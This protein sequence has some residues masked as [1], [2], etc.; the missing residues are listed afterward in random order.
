MFLDWLKCT[1]GRHKQVRIHWNRDYDNAPEAED[2]EFD[3]FVWCKFLPLG[4]RV[5]ENFNDLYSREAKI[6]TTLVEHRLGHGTRSQGRRAQF[7]CLGQ[8]SDLGFANSRKLER[9]VL[10]GSESFYNFSRTEVTTWHPKPRMTRS[11][12]LFDAKFCHSAY[13]FAET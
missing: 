7:F 3:S 1:L 4:L 13:N 9:C 2:D 11:I 12:L 8:L 5:R 10:S 6:F